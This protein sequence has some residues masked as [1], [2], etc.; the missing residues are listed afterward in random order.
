MKLEE[1]N[2]DVIEAFEILQRNGVEVLQLAI[3]RA[4]YEALSTVLD[5]PNDT[6]IYINDVPCQI[7]ENTQH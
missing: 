7:F 3:S 2:K 6:C 5:V 1:F 4:T